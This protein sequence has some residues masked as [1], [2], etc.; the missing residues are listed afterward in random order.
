ML[1]ALIVCHNLAKTGDSQILAGF[2][3]AIL[4]PP[5]FSDGEVEAS[6]A[7]QVKA[8]YFKHL[9]F[10][11]TCLDTEVR[12]YAAEWLFLLCN[13]NGKHTFT[14]RI[15]NSFIVY[16]GGSPITLISKS[17]PCYT[18]HNKILTIVLCVGRLACLANEY[19]R[20]T[21]VG[22]AIGLLRMKGLA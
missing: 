2:K 17:L 13:E 6:K 19:T 16:L 4:S 9:K 10:F 3:D 15:L 12:R 22:N 1:P 20:H 14:L 18:P 21:G 5:S 11:L 8:F 7:D